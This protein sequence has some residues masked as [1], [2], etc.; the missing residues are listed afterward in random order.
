MPATLLLADD[1]ITIQRVI[2]LTFAN[3]DIRVIAVGDGETAVQ[4][5]DAERPDIVLADVG[6]PKLDGYG[7]ARH[8]KQSPALKGIPVLLLTGAFEPVDEEKARATGCDGI[9]VKPVEPQQLIGRVKDLLAGRHGSELW[10]AVLPR[11]DA[12]AHAPAAPFSSP[13]VP[14]AAARAAAGAPHADGGFDIEFDELDGALEA[15]DSDVVEQPD[16]LARE[17]GIRGV[18][19]HPPAARGRAFGDWDIPRLAPPPVEPDAPAPLPPPPPP[20]A[21]VVPPVQP[22]VPAVVAVP[23]PAAPPA[24]RISLATAFSALLAAEH[25]LSAAQRAPAAAPVSDA[26]IEEIVQR[27]LARMTQDTVRRVVAE[28]AERLIREEIGKLKSTHE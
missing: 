12:V 19:A 23:G 20:P 17:L 8:I 4:R 27:V 25:S 22:P 26:A 2:E 24:S 6:M 7:V 18:Q 21:A 10:P 1:S 13:P 16:E 14:D 5:I 3:E 28:T 9:L 15:L 11:V